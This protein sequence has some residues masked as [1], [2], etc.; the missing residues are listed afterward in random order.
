MFAALVSYEGVVL[1]VRVP[2]FATQ[3]LHVLQPHVLAAVQR[4]GVRHFRDTIVTFL[5]IS[6]I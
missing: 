1:R 3:E 6:L 4:G 2:S 5:H